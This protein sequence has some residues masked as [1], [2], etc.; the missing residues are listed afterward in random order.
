MLFYSEWQPIRRGHR[1]NSN[2]ISS[3]CRS[4][5]RSRSRAARCACKT[6]IAEL[7][8]GGHLRY[9]EATTNAYYDATYGRMVAAL[10]AVRPL[11]EKTVLS[12][13]EQFWKTVAPQM[14]ECPF[15]LCA[16]D[17][18]VHD[19]RGKSTVR[20]FTNSGTRRLI[21]GPFRTIQSASI[22]S[23]S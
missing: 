16:L 2:C 4:S 5:I 22:R 20:R 6:L 19:L 10:E 3:I 15:A 18:A 12:E 1:C 17:E 14:S 8:E 13:P 21:M 7:R 9:G 11:I 23:S